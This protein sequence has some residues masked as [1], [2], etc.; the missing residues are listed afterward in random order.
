MQGKYLCK[1]GR[2]DFKE[3]Q[4]R[5]KASGKKLGQFFKRSGHAHPSVLLPQE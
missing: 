4:S 5:I 3:L 1:K 2:M